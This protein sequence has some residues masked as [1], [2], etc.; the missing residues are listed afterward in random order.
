MT[1]VPRA[2]AQL[3]LPRPGPHWTMP[4]D[5]RPDEAIRLL[6]GP[7]NDPPRASYGPTRVIGWAR[8]R[9]KGAGPMAPG[10]GGPAGGR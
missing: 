2:T 5:L 6:W 8:T 4:A 1:S 7:D 10:G 3:Q 9:R